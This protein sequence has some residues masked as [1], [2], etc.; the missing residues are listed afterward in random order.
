MRNLK[1][2]SKKGPKNSLKAQRVVQ[3]FKI[4]IKRSIDF[5][6]FV[7]IVHSFQTIEFQN[8]KNERVVALAP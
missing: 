3:N 5:K 2:K 7:D 1:P 8:L 4:S 6:G